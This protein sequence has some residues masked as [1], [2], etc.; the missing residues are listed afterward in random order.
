MYI[1]DREHIIIVITRFNFSICHV[2]SDDINSNVVIFETFFD[3]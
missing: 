3:P 1:S 2:L